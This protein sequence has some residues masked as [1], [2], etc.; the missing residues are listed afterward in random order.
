MLDFLPNDMTL[1]SAPRHYYHL[2]LYFLAA[3]TL[4]FSSTYTTVF[5]LFIH[6]VPSSNFFMLYIFLTCVSIHMCIWL[7]AYAWLY[8]VKFFALLEMITTLF[9]ILVGYNCISL[10]LLFVLCSVTIN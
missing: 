5:I 10:A 3:L 4:F 9:G 8:S 6:I 2:P 7:Y 1:F